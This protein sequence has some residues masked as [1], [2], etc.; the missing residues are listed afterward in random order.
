MVSYENWRIH[1]KDVGDSVDVYVECPGESG[2]V[3]SLR[4]RVLR[5]KPDCVTKAVGKAMREVLEELG[6]ET[7]KKSWQVINRLDGNDTFIAEG[8][9]MNE[10]AFAALSA[11]GWSLSGPEEDEDDEG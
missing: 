1:F 10:A 11:L 6:R 2:I 4:F 5:S 7:R 8:E 9:D 3:E